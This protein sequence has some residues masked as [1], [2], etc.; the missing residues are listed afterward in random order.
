MVSGLTLLTS[1]CMI[2][3]AR[4]SEDESPLA[5][6]VVAADEETWI[7]REAVRCVRGLRS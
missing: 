1:P 4:I 2:H 6:Y 7:A 3:A 5:A